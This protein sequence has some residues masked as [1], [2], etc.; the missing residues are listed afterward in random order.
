MKDLALLQRE[1]AG[2][3]SNK[4]HLKLTTAEQRQITKTYTTDSEAHQLYLRGRFHWNKRN[5][6]DFKRA[7]AYFE[8]AVEKDPNYALAY[9]GLADTYALMPLYGGLRPKDFMLLAKR[10][11]VKALEVDE[12]LAEAHASLGRLLNSY[13]FDWPGA[14]REFVR[15]IELN[16]NYP[17]VH[18][19]YAEFLAF[20][21]RHDEALR[22]ISRALEL[23][24][25]SL[26]INRMKGNILSFAGRQDEAL[27]Q[28]NKTADLYPENALV[29][30]NLGDIFTLKGMRREAVEQYLIAFKLDGQSTTE[31]QKFRD[32]FQRNGWPGFWS[33]YLK[34]LLESQKTALEKDKN[35]YFK[36]ESLAFAYA[37]NKDK[38]KAL[39]YLNRAFEDRDPDLIT[40]RMSPVYD[41]L[42]DDP[43]FKEL[44]K[45]IGLPE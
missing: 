8:Q 37:A 2:D 19:W 29:R 34:T 4:L 35:A 14:E 39:E 42:A 23:D 33:E 44:L 30:Y 36:N 38:D 12:N 22:E 21:G 16:P 27:A 17:T 11:A 32:A 3:V 24:P 1:V 9:A 31:V 25:L 7:V 10:S 13:D 26:V 41:F 40:I 20:S 18:Q 28:L 43:R 6:R 15:A 45:K 5:I